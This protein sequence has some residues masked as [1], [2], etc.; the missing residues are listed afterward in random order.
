VPRSAHHHPT[1]AGPYLLRYAQEASWREDNRRLSNGEQSN[2][3]R[4][5]TRNAARA[6]P[7]IFGGY[8]QRHIRQPENG[9]GGDMQTRNIF[10]RS[11]QRGIKPATH[12]LG[13]SWVAML[14]TAAR[15][16]Q[17][18]GPAGG[19]YAPADTKLVHCPCLT[20]LQN[21]KRGPKYATRQ[22]KTFSKRRPKRQ[23]TNTL[24]YAGDLTLMHRPCV[25]IVGSR[26]RDNRTGRA[27]ATRLA[28]ELVEAGIVVVSGLARGID[29]AGPYE[30]HR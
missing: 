13:A 7:S 1:L 22:L 20:L 2:Q 10:V 23:K 30:R 4:R 6:R 3:P 21:A 26:E 29:A 25:S 14:M 8:W 24:F 16:T 27:R 18:N 17:H 9:V 5:R 11:P 19:R 12:F 15:S 28:R